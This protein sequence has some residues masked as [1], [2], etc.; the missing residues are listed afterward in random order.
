MEGIG[1]LLRGRIRE[2]VAIACVLATLGCATGASRQGWRAGLDAYEDGRFEDA[3]LIWLEALAQADEAGVDDP[4]LTES[5]RVLANLYVQT[6]RFEP[7]QPMLE[8]W[9]E[10]RELRGDVLDQTPPEDVDEPDAP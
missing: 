8:R 4:R 2:I 1:P 7:A 6:G 5:L 10:I 9:V 3:E